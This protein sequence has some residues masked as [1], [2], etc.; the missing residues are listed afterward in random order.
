MPLCLASREDRPLDEGAPLPTT[1]APSTSPAGS[2]DGREAYVGVEALTGVAEG[3]LRVTEAALRVGDATL[4]D[5]GVE[6]DGD[7]GAP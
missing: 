1:T 4:D 2:L 5:I 7:R 6:R 3:A